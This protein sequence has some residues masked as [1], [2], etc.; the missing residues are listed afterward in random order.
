MKILIATDCYIPTINGVVISTVNLKNEL[1]RMGHEVRVLTLSHTRRSYEKQGD[2]F[3]GSAGAQKVYPE[4]RF[5]LP[6]NNRLIE[7]LIDW[8]PDI[9]HSQSEFSTFVIARRI[10]NR[11]DIPIV[12]TYHT[13]YE[14]YTHYFS[15]VKKWGKRMAE[16]FTNSSLK[17][18]NC[19][20]APSEKVKVLLRG[21]GMKGEIKVIPSGI[22]IN[23]FHTPVQNSNLE[24]IKQT[25]GLLED[26]KILITIGRLAKEKNHEELLA[27]IK[28]L[29][30]SDVKLVI[31]GDGPN[32]TELEI[33][34][35]KLG[36]HDKVIFAGMI[37]HEDIGEYYQ[38]GDVFVSASNSETQ[39]LTYYEALANGIPVICRKDESIAN[40][41]IN[42]FN[43]WQYETFEEFSD[44]LTSVLDKKN[45]HFNKNAF[46]SIRSNYSLEAFAQNV[47]TAYFETIDT[48]RE[49]HQT[50]RFSSTINAEKKRARQ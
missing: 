49:Y 4:A 19:V 24:K 3:I 20:I 14:D 40:I 46:E 45:D 13:I 22:D 7:E 25:L 15:P 47:E 5:T 34:A 16:T 2:V 18:V 27:F 9:I 48:F 37:P 30:R 23:K 50:Q 36:I 11:L 1:V 28:E 26:Q 43:G 42:G 44:Q 35:K 39:G 29:N 21:Y 8:N 31:V 17:H 6:R 10:A 12:H 38:I 41:V 33:Y 32:R